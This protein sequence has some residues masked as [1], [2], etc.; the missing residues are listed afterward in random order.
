MKISFLSL[1]LFIAGNGLMVTQTHAGFLDSL[2]NQAVQYALDG[3]TQK[4]LGFACYA[5]GLVLTGCASGAALYNFTHWPRKVNEIMVSETNNTQMPQILVRNIAQLIQQTAQDNV[6]SR[7]AFIL[8]ALA[9]GIPL[10]VLGT[11]L[12]FKK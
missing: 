4:F 7:N 5:G 6:K 2:K 3:N 11:Y 9:L 12:L 10:T 1:L 8:K